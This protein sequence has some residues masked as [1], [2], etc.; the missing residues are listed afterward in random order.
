[1]SAFVFFLQILLRYHHAR[2]LG[3]I[4][5]DVHC[6]RLCFDKLCATFSGMDQISVHKTTVWRGLLDHKKVNDIIRQFVKLATPNNNSNIVANEEKKRNKYDK[7][8]ESILPFWSY[9]CSFVC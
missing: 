4:E 5:L 8:T 2:C 9:F 3:M 1:M 6:L 7:L